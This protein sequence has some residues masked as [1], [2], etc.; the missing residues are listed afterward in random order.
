MGAA[1]T[2]SL[3]EKL[4]QTTAFLRPPPLS[5]DSS[6]QNGVLCHLNSLFS[7]WE[8]LCSKIFALTGSDP[9]RS[10]V[11]LASRL[12]CSFYSRGERAVIL[13]GQSGSNPLS[14]KGG[15]AVLTFTSTYKADL[16]PRAHWEGCMG[17][18][19]EWGFPGV[20]RGHGRG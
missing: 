1:A 7:S 18:S 20:G 17:D 9:D 19:G 12:P 6:R 11:N 16:G 3:S 2:F 5:R 13:L 4:L 8:F 14:G 15:W 10:K